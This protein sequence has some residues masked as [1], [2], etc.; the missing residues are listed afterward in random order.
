[1]G[2]KEGFI[3]RDGKRSVDDRAPPQYQQQQSC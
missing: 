1:V 2:H 3:N